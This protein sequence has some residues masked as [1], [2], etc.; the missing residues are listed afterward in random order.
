MGRERFS[1]RVPAS[2]WAHVSYC[3]AGRFSLSGFQY[4]Y[5]FH[6]QYLH[7]LVL[8]RSRCVD[9]NILTFRH[10]S[11]LNMDEGR[12]SGDNVDVSDIRNS[13]RRRLHGLVCRWPFMMRLLIPQQSLLMALLCEFSPAK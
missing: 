4:S 3:V 5:P 11:V 8:L 2:C 1:C 9:T 12:S 6:S 10:T 7:L 13:C